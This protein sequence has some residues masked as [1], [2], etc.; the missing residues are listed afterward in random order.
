MPGNIVTRNRDVVLAYTIALAL[1]GTAH[2]LQFVNE[3]QGKRLA[4]PLP[5]LGGW[6]S[7]IGWS[8]L[9]LFL[10]IMSEIP[11]TSQLGSSF[12]WLILLTVFF[13]YGTAAF[14]NLIALMGQGAGTPEP[15]GTTPGSDPEFRT[16]IH[17]F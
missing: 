7:L 9:F 15:G 5:R 4:N 2:G 14:Q 17:P 8:A 16:G 11:A 10:I 12:A 6:N 1:F 13:V 3:E